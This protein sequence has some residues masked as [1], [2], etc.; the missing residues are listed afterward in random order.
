LGPRE[1][2]GLS[3]QAIAPEIFSIAQKNMATDFD[4]S[5]EIVRLLNL[6]RKTK[7]RKERK[8]K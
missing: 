2:D 7:E 8:R 5:G 6:V 4:I 1:W 3:K